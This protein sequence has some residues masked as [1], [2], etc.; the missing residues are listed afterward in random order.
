MWCKIVKQRSTHP[1]KQT[2]P[3]TSIRAPIIMAMA[4]MITIDIPEIN[5]YRVGMSY[6]NP[7]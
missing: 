1:L 6:G 2:N 5:I 4:T 7:I 3:I